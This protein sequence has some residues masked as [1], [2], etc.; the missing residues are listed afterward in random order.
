MPADG[1]AGRNSRLRY[2]EEADMNKKS[3]LWL[4]LF[5][6][7]IVCIVGI[8]LVYFQMRAR[9]FNS[10]P[11]VLI[12]SPINHAQFQA[13][14]GVSVHATIRSDNGVSRAELWADQSLIASREVNE[15]SAPAG[16]VF[17]ADW[18]ASTMGNHVLIVR[19]FSSDGTAGQ[20]STVV[21]VRGSEEADTNATTHIVQEGET[22]ESIAAEY[23]TTPEELVA[24]NPA[25]HRLPRL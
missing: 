20:A 13:G 25:Q 14:N 18:I 12:H 19:A 3:C 23:G 4:G 16:L 10:R 9:A 1:Q 15:G 6:L 2:R 22:V 17:S 21:E 7:I 8:A 11:L 5:V 24:S